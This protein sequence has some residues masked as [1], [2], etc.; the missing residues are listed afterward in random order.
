MPLLFFIDKDILEDPACRGIDDVVLSYTFFRHV[1][2]TYFLNFPPSNISL[3][4]IYRARRNAQG[5]LEPDAS[6]QDVQKSLG[7]GDYEMAPRAE[8]RNAKQ[9]KS[10]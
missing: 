3:L 1:F 4:R 5:H 2:F 6:D 9:E 7:F 8:I 10:S